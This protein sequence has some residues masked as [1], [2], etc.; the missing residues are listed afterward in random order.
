MGAVFGMI[1]GAPIG[2]IMSAL[3]SMFGFLTGNDTTE[4]VLPYDEST[5]T[6]WTYDGVD[7]PYLKLVGSET[8][9][10]L[11]IFSFRRKDN[12]FLKG[13]SGGKVMEIVFTDKNGNELI[14]YAVH[15]ESDLFRI[16]FY[17]K[18]DV[19]I[20]EYT[21]KAD[22][23]VRGGYWKLSSTTSY[24]SASRRLLY[25]SS[26]TSDTYTF[27]FIVPQNDSIVR[28]LNKLDYVNKKGKQ[29]EWIHISFTLDENNQLV[30]LSEEKGKY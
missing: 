9:G 22:S 26:E 25:A 29:V 28:H 13:S 16:N 23:A 11:Q 19:Y 8:D 15:D 12:F 30:L 3:I 27:T 18:E 20:L 14:Y 6:V 10:D 24:D 7:D 4:L 1:L 2:I 21:A 5:G 17:P